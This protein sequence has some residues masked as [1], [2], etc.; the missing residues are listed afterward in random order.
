MAHGSGGRPRLLA[1]DDEPYVLE[2][3]RDRLH[4]S[5]DVRVAS[6]GDEGLELLRRDPNGYAVVISDM[7]MPGMPGD[8]FLREARGVAPDAVRMLLTGYAELDS[9]IRA[10][11]DAQLFRFLTKPLEPE[12]LMRAC[13]AALG[14]HRLQTAERV[15]L[16]ETLMGAVDALVSTL[17]LASPAAFGRGNRVR[18]HVS[19]IADALELED[20]WEVEVASVLAQI[21]AVTLPPD[22]AARWYSGQTLSPEERDMVVRI[23]GTGLRLLEKIPRLDGVREILSTYHVTPTPGDPPALGDMPEPA[24]LLRIATDYEA[25]ESAGSEPLVAIATM[26]SRRIYDPELLECLREVLGIAAGQDTRL[27]DVAV[28]EL[29]LGM[30]LADDVRNHAGGLL[31][32]RGHIV[33]EHMLTLLGNVRPGLIREPLR[34]YLGDGDGDGSAEE[35]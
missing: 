30:T 31:V 19:R 5:F 22:T 32:A 3:L 21:G 8:A 12:E 35:L 7:R 23:P 9:A 14:Q 26:R 6:S 33:D 28:D 4:R 25:L 27:R 16:E 17:A 1:V 10:V 18:K 15:L 34:I 29:E 13:Q 2:G 11:N 20:R 24:R